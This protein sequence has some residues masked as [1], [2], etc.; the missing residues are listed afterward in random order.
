MSALL[1][2]QDLTVTTST[3]RR[4]LDGVSWSLDAGGRLGVVGESGSGKSMTALAVLGLLPDGMRATGRVLLDGE[5]LLALPPRRLAR[6]RGGQVAMVFQ[7]PLTALDP[8]MTVGRQITG[9]LRLHRG[10][11]GAAARE[12]AA[13]LARLV[14]LDDT[15]R[16]LGS[17]P[18]QL[19]GGQRQRVALAMA[20][21]CE[22]R[23][24]L[25]DEPTT[26]LDVT[27]QAEVLDL[28]DHLVDRTGVALV[29]V[30]HDLPVVARVARDLVVMR[31][32]RVV[33]HTSVAAAL[34][35]GEAAYTRE[36]VGAARA[37]TGLP[38]GGP[39][40][41]AAGVAAAAARR[42]APEEETR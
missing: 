33:E 19:S 3:G 31:D 22:P 6:V 39:A 9:P 21:A 12:E 10:L 4:I 29:L 30:T 36:L 17:Y 20:L 35:G 42:P 13:R 38:G 28:L 16:I 25:A 26:A 27:V 14:H 1:E 15:E 40:A 24:L 41:G 34:A 37:V 32:G 7:E 23:V 2:V 18:W 11:R 5:D 8:L